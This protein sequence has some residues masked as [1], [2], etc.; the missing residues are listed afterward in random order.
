MPQASLCRFSVVARSL[1]ALLAVAIGA[2][3]DAATLQ[4]PAQFPTIAAAVTASVNGD[5]IEIA[6][7]TYELT[8]PVAIGTKL[9]TIRGAVDA[10]GAPATV[11]SGRNVNRHFTFNLGTNPTLRFENLRMTEGRA[12]FGGAVSSDRGG[13]TFRNCVFDSNVALSNGPINGLG[14]AVAIL[15]TSGNSLGSQLVFEDCVFSGNSASNTTAAVNGAGGAVYLSNNC[16]A[17]FTR[18]VFVGNSVPLPDRG[19]GGAVM[20]LGSH[21]SSVRVSFVDCVV[22]GNTAWS[23]GGLALPGDIGELRGTRVVGN[24]TLDPISGDWINLGGNCIA[25][26]NIDSDGDGV[27]DECDTEADTEL[28]V[29]D[30]YPTLDDAI[31]AAAPYARIHLPAG[32]LSVTAPIVLGG[33]FLEVVGAVDADGA[34]ATVIDGGGQTSLLRASD[35]WF[36]NLVFQNSFSDARALEIRRGAVRLEN[37]VISGHLGGGLLATERANLRVGGCR[38]EG[39]ASANSGGAMRIE[40]STLHIEETEFLENRAGAGTSTTFFAGGALYV[41][42]GSQADSRQTVTVLHCDFDGNNVP[43]GGGGIGGFAGAAMFESLR[44]TIDFIGNTVRNNWCVTQCAV[45]SYNNTLSSVTR[46]LDCVFENNAN[47]GILGEGTF[48]LEVGRCIFRQNTMHALNGSGVGVRLY[49]SLFEGNQCGLDFSVPWATVNYWSPNVAGGFIRNC[50]FR[51]NTSLS[52]GVA[53]RFSSKANT[54]IEGCR[55]ENN[56][57]TSTTAQTAGAVHATSQPSPD[58]PRLKDSVMCGNA[59]LQISSG[60]VSLGGNCM[61]ASCSDADGNGLPDGCEPYEDGVHEVPGEFA[62]IGAALAVAGPNDV[63][64]LAPGVHA[65]T[66]EIATIQRDLTL[67]GAVEESSELD[68]VR[69]LA[70]CL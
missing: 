69:C 60:V 44:G 18:C 66:A 7:G 53:I 25:V 68:R 48:L 22:E 29:P 27:P 32:V 45:G 1:G 39:N 12:A 19:T 13:A 47:G 20:S 61:I 46:V 41:I 34:P 70:V 55:F 3:V 4:V 62:S 52:N 23:V 36:R 64:Q 37:C 9:I 16:G 49:D 31:R 38:F 6:A 5:V 14:G 58:R 54:L 33:K 59:G 56:T 10:K 63:V 67:R 2:R 21:T 40:T 42:G 15:N 65:L 8:E 17:S 28:F 26:V 50:V 51:H 43:V 35:G 57:S 30:E 24:G 11:L